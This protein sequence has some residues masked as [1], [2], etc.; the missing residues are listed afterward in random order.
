[1]RRSM[2][3]IVAAAS[4]LLVATACDDSTNDPPPASA[5]YQLAFKT[6]WSAAT[7]PTDFPI[8]P[9]FSGLIGASHKSETHLWQAGELS[10]P[11]IKNMA[12][13]GSKSPLGEEIDALIASGEACLKISDVGIN[14]PSPETVTLT[15]TVTRDC[16]IVSIVSMIAPSPD[17]F[18]GVDSVRL[19]EDGAWV[20]QKVIELY[21]FDAGTDSGPTYASPNAVT[22]PPETISRIEGDPFL[23]G[24]SVAPLGTFTFSRLDES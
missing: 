11:G 2:R 21:P 14:Y 22:S 10:S 6:T 18:V 8:S 12:E 9:H 24:G 16:P 7:H 17:W 5:Q 1:M 3:I 15:L 23:N 13:T 19:Y 20:N 4:L